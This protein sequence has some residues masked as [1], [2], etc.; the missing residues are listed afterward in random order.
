MENTSFRIYFGGKVDR[1]LAD[2]T[3]FGERG[4]RKNE[5]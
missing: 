2:L 5:R 4:K 3:E 1:S